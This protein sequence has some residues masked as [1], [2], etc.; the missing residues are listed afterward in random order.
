MKKSSTFLDS[1]KHCCRNSNPLLQHINQIKKKK[2]STFLDSVVVVAFGCV[3]DGAA[4]DLEPL[5]VGKH[6]ACI[7]SFMASKAL[8]SI[9]LVL[10]SLWDSMA[11]KG[12][13]ISP[14]ETLHKKGANFAHR[15]RGKHMLSRGGGVVVG[16]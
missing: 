14:H 3:N 16:G 7:I 1:A 6:L 12:A 8:T 4:V 13:I 5:G 10:L 9:I 11:A 2:N 15:G